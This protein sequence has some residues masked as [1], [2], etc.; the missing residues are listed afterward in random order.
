MISLKC[1]SLISKLFWD[2]NFFNSIRSTNILKNIKYPESPIRPVDKIKSKLPFYIWK[3]LNMTWTYFSLI[4]TY[5]QKS[6]LSLYPK[7]MNLNQSNNNVYGSIKW[8]FVAS[9]ILFRFRWSQP[10]LFSLSQQESKLLRGI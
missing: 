7:G 8:S 9:Q 1:S 3:C 6:F 10:K 4:S 5:L 2:Q